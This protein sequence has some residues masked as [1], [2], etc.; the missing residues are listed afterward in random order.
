MFYVIYRSI[1]HK[2][3]IYKELYNKK[4][5][6]AEIRKITVIWDQPNGLC[7]RMSYFKQWLISDDPASV[8]PT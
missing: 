3:L 2:Y 8:Y 1:W 6:I 4:I 7:S 5:Y